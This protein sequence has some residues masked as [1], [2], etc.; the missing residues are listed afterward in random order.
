MGVG[1]VL[2]LA[3]LLATF[4]SLRKVRTVQRRVVDDLTDRAGFL[5]AR[6]AGLRIAVSKRRNSPEADFDRA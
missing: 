5:R 6:F 2:L 1:L 3:L 4:R